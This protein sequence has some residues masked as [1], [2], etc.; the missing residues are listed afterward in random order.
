MA[1]VLSGLFR[2]LYIDSQ[3]NEYTKAFMAESSFL[4]SYSSMIRGEASYYFIEALEDAEVLAFRYDD[5]LLLR[6]TD[7]V[8]NDLL[9]RLLEKGYSVKERRERELLLLDADGGPTAVFV[10]AAAR[11]LNFCAEYPDLNERVKQHQVASF[12]GIKPESL[13]RIKK[14]SKLNTGQ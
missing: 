8:W 6:K 5:W 3:G 9:V 4:S 14:K 1:I 10:D 2:Y 11:Y 13:S 12:L 7:P